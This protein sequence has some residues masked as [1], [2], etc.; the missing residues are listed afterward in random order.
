MQEIDFLKPISRAWLKIGEKN[1]FNWLCP[2]IY[3]DISCVTE[4][5]KTDRF[6]FA[7]SG[8]INLSRKVLGIK[9]IY[10]KKGGGI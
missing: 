1:N 7:F 2:N 5:F 4:L 6:R 3:F 8:N 10:N 9:I